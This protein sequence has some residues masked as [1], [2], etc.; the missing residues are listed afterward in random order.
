MSS[1]WSTPSQ[2]GPGQ[3]M[4]GADADVAD[5]GL[6]DIGLPPPPQSLMSVPMETSRPQLTRNQPQPPPPHQPPPPPAPQQIGNPQDSLT[7]MQLRRIVTDI[8]KF[9]PTSYAF[10]YEDTATFEE[11][12]DEWFSYNEAEFKRLF[13]AKNTFEKRWKKFNG[14]IWPVNSQVLADFVRQETNG[15]ISTSLRTRCK[16]LQTIMHVVLGVWDETAVDCDHEEMPPEGKAKCSKDLNGDL[17]GDN[18]KGGPK[19]KASREQLEQMKKGIQAVS[20]SGSISL[21]FRV[22]QDSFKRFW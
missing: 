3:P 14:G 17:K 2:D 5:T 20:D 15:L 21:L 22:M 8:P 19:T 10:E 11:E 1:L 18:N 7:L 13:R 9:D 6:A 4:D 12:V 16:S